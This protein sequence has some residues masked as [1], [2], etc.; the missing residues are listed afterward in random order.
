MLKELI[1]IRYDCKYLIMVAL[2]LYH[3][4]CVGLILSLFVLYFVRVASIYGNDLISVAYILDC[5]H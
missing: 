4:P 3:Q 5:R 2:V 1:T